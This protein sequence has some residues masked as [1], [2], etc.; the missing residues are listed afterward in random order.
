MS[1]CISEHDVLMQLNILLGWMSFALYWQECNI[2]EYDQL[3][4]TCCETI[5]SDEHDIISMTSWS[6]L[7]YF[8]NMLL[9]GL[10]ITF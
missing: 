1:H 5:Y 4:T 3:N 8:Q 9:H 2:Q 7:L 10:L 6:P